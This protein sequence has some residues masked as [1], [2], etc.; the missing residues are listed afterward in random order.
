[1][2]R[3]NNPL[4]LKPRSYRKL[5]L[6]LAT[7]ITLS[8]LVL[9]YYG[10]EICHLAPLLPARAV[11][12]GGIVVFIAQDIKNGQNLWRSIGGQEAGTL[13]EARRAGCAGLAARRGDTVCSTIG[14]RERAA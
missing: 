6:S 11:A 14:K 8:F 9:R 3:Q 2:S 10:R 5:Y 7:V 13:W 4:T 12:S 1:M